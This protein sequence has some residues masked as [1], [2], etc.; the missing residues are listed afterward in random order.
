MTGTWDNSSPILIGYQYPGTIIVGAGDI[1]QV[2]GRI[3]LSYLASGDLEI[4]DGGK[5][6][7][8]EVDIGGQ[9]GDDGT[10]SVDGAKSNW[11]S[12][13][14]MF[15]GLLGDGD[16]TISDGGSVNVASI[17]V[18]S[19]YNGPA[20]AD[21]MG[22]IDI[23]TRGT[24]TSGGPYDNIGQAPGGVGE[25]TVDGSGSAWTN[26]G[27]LFCG[28]GGHGT[29]TVSDSGKLVQTGNLFIGFNQ[30]GVGTLNITTDGQA[31]VNGELNVGYSGM[32]TLS[33]Q[34]G[35]TLD[36]QGPYDSVA[37]SNGGQGSVTVTGAD[38]L[39]KSAGL[40]SV[41]ANGG[42][43]TISASDGGAVQAAQGLTISTGSSLS[44]DGSSV[45]EAGSAGGA[46]P[47]YV[48]IDAG[49]SLFG[50]GTVNGSVVD[51]GSIIASGGTLTLMGPLSGAGTLT[52]G[53]SSTLDLGGGATD[54]GIN[55]DS[56][57][58]VK[59]E[60]DGNSTITG[61]SG[62]DAI[63]IIGNGGNS[64]TIGA[65]T[66]DV[67]IKGTGA[68]TIS[69]GTSSAGITITNFS[70]SLIGSAPAAEATITLTGTDG[71]S[72]TIGSNSTLE[73]A[74]GASLTG[75]IDFGSTSGGTL[76]IDGTMPTNAIEGFGPGDVVDLK[77]VPLDKSGFTLLET[78]PSAQGYN[79]LQ[80]VDGSNHQLNLQ[81]PENFTGGFTLSA[82]PSGA[83]TDIMAV[84]SF[85]PGSAVIGSPTPATSPYN[86]PA[87]TGYSTHPVS[88]TTPNPYSAVVQ[89]ITTQGGVLKGEAAGFIIDANSTG[90]GIILTAAHV[91]DDLQPGQQISIY[92]ADAAFGSGGQP[93][94]A[95]VPAADLKPNPAYSGS[96]FLPDPQ[97]DFGV[98]IVPQQISLSSFGVL[99]VDTTF[100]GGTVNV[101]GYPGFT[102]QTSTQF[103]QLGP[104]TEDSSFGSGVFD[105]DTPLSLG[106]D[107]GGPL[108]IYNGAT[109][110]AVGIVSGGNLDVQL[111][112]ED[113][114]IIENLANGS[115]EEGKGEDGYISGATVF[116][117]DNGTG[118]LA[119]NDAST[120]TD[121]NGN[122]TLTGGSG[123]LIAFGGTD[124]STGLAFKGQLEAP[125]GSTIIDPLTTLISGLQASAGLTVAAAEQKVL[126][127]LG[128]PSNVDLTT[129]DPI[130]GAKAGDAVSAE[131]FAAGAKVIDTADAIASA[132]AAAGISFLAA[133]KDAYAGLE[134]D[135]KTLAAGQTLDLTDQATIAALIN[136]VAKTE[137]V[138]A[139]S[140]VSAVA[141]NIAA[142]NA[143]LDQKLAQDGADSSLIT[144]VSRVQA[145]IQSSIF[146]LT[147]GVDTIDGGPENNLAT[148]IAGADRTRRS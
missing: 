92:S 25:V 114:T 100:S 134:S 78:T 109:A 83:G 94:F 60:G 88:G 18:G 132:F 53:A 138:N 54:G 32:G 45:I 85:V 130:A 12:T 13:G 124:I 129:L 103:T 23:E 68:N 24:L 115:T 106:G 1:L 21:E 19:N 133:F 49:S 10:A 46:P 30:G 102:G 72:A 126:A 17:N 34:S 77:N 112:S 2:G 48:T 62:N 122:F 136:A 27:V 70:G 22:T 59:I 63:T 99:P 52:V 76:Q 43:G 144:D 131:A 104:V 142:S 93:V 3:S 65:G 111:T 87:L 140:F 89:I 118:Q 119:S 71:G 105:E 47:G 51:N 14:G 145:A 108:W 8:G 135:I 125:S 82:D 123:P 20:T 147:N 121:S 4:E 101:T 37:S 73:L 50:A 141:A 143:S 113:K 16:V 61:G 31:T 56:N 66:D 26:N 79:V 80:I 90:G 7:S 81:L 44:V 91:L 11:T 110:N 35:G 6:T 107:S 86:T 69:A 36:S 58:T 9:S 33:I 5:V 29:L 74:K 38:S 57:G 42:T 64:V 137:D 95:K 117:D 75:T 39:W 128:L 67:T 116:A 98:I 40:I 28:S 84:P 146:H 15:V 97:N 148:I 96:A 127:A 41:G 55:F 120:T 139:S